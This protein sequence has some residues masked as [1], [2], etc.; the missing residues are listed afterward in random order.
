M[1]VKYIQIVDHRSFMV[2]TR[3]RLVKLLNLN[4]IR[5]RQFLDA[6]SI[7]EHLQLLLQKFVIVLLLLLS[8][9][10]VLL[11]LLFFTHRKI[12]NKS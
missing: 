1:L 12:R 2:A 7:P 3:A 4:I 6:E 5:G 10:Y 11:R 8:L 9:L